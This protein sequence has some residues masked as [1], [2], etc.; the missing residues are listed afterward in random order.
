MDNNLNNGQQPVN[1][2]P[3]QPAQPIQPAQTSQPIQPAQASQPMQPTQASQPMQPTQ[4]SQPIQPTQPVQPSQPM[5]SA[6]SQMFYQT[7]AKSAPANILSILAI[8]LSAAGLLFAVV[9][10]FWSCSASAENSISDQKFQGSLIFFIA[11][12]GL[13]LAIAGVVLVVIP[14]IQKKQLD[15]MQKISIA[16]ATVAIVM[17]LLPNITIC[18]YNS[19]LNHVDD[20]KAQKK[21]NEELKKSSSSGSSVSDYS[22][23]LDDYLR[24]YL[25]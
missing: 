3:E 11:F 19:A 5:Q 9:G 8:S 2:T 10:T 4:A 22:D 7:N 16:V 1:V 21:A 14:L 25:N 18:A 13:M 20:N 23:Y 24:D 6:Q 17:A 15:M 12:F